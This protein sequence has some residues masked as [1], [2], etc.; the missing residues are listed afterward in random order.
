[1]RFRQY[2]IGEKVICSVSKRS[3]HPGPR[4]HH[5]RPEISG[6]GYHYQVDKFWTVREVRQSQ[7]V[8]LTRRG[9]L[10]VV[11]GNDPSIHRARWWERLIYWGRFPKDAGF[12][13]PAQQANA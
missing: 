8:L 9:K 11:D 7:L 13:D 3:A 6:E 5:V 4:A 12:A 1:M 2:Q 10:H